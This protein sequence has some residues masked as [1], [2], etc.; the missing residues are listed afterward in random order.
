MDILQGPQN[1]HY[2]GKKQRAPLGLIQSPTSWKGPLRGGPLDLVALLR[3]DTVYVPPY[4]Y[5][6]LR[7]RADNRGIWSLHYHILW[8]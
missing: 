4:G 6:V 2:V 1:K 5:A 3:R 7:V 8:H